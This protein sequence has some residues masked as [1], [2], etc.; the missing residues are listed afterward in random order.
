MDKWISQDGVKWVDIV[1]VFTVTP[2][3]SIYSQLKMCL[4]KTK[5]S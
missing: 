3:G 4:F 5:T 2:L 1:R